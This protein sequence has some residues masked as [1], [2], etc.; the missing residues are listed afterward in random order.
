M[1]KV[2]KLQTWPA[3]WPAFL[4]TLPTTNV[5]DGPRSA[6]VRNN[7]AGHVSGHVDRSVATFVVT[8]WPCSTWPEHDPQDD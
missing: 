3:M 1:K 6:T 5:V 8:L 4:A 2:E 7:A